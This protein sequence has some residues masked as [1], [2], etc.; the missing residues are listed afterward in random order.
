MTRLAIA[1]PPRTAELP[2]RPLAPEDLAARLSAAL[3]RA[4]LGPVAV[5]LLPVIVEIGA[6]VGG[7]WGS[8]GV[9]RAL[10]AWGEADRA[11]SALRHRFASPRRLPPKRAL[12]HYVVG[13][14]AGRNPGYRGRT[15][16]QVE[17]D[18]RHGYA[19]HDRL[20]YELARPY[21]RTGYEDARDDGTRPG[22]DGELG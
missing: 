8:G 1:V 2:R 22:P 5:R 18:L 19:R 15:F 21:L 10:A 6:S 13:H 20:V 3:A 9:V 4:G 12:T 11:R 14:L 16:E 17:L 7:W